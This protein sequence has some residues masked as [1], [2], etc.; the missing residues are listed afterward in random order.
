MRRVHVTTVAMETRPC[1]HL[2][3][4][5][6]LRVDVNKAKMLDVAIETQPRVPSGLFPNYKIF[7]TAVDVINVKISI[8]HPPYNRCI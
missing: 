6:Y 7:R 2:F 5:V 8:K 3:I 1:F 4:V